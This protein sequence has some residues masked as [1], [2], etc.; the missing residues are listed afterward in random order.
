MSAHLSCQ[1]LASTGRLLVCRLALTT[2]ANTWEYSSASECSPASDQFADVRSTSIL[3]TLGLT[4]RSFIIFMATLGISDAIHTM[5]MIV[6]AFAPL[7][8]VA[9]DIL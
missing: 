4:Y 8:V 2:L 7:V 6:P 1:V 3:P 5:A 9:E